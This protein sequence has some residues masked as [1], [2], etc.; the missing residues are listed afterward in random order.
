M[1]SEQKRI[2]QSM[3]PQQK[4]QIAMDLY[5]TARRL[6]AAGLKSQHPDWTEK[7]IHQKVREIFLNA[8]S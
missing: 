7:E 5:N 1:H 6:K 8:R 3:T 2:Y 4:L